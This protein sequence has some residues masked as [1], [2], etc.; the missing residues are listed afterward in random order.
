MC[1]GRGDGKYC[2]TSQDDCK[3]SRAEMCSVDLTKHE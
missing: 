1:L 2:D 3:H